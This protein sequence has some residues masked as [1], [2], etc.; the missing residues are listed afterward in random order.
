MSDEK[1]MELGDSNA[2]HPIEGEKADQDKDTNA[3]RYELSIEDKSSFS[4]TEED[5]STLRRVS[6]SIPWISY[7][8]CVVEFAERASYYGMVFVFYNF[9]QFPLP[10]GGNG[11]GA[12][13]AGT[14]ETAG[15]LNQGLA[16]SSALTMLFQCLSFTV[17]IFGG[18]I[19][20]TKLGRFKT[21]C[22]GVV[23][24]GLAHAILVV[25]A[26]PSVLQA[27]NGMAPF[28]VGFI[29]LALGTG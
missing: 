23:F 8:L 25:G 13:P 14:Q 5:R 1:A 2:L 4:I 29:T 26:L 19:A 16:I 9:I 27:G 11:A 3:L 6:G 10:N 21:I 15:A 17:P 7:A 20:D 22:I 24:C 28:V 18:W 12:P